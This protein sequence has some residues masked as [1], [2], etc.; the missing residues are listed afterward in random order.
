MSRA[1]RVYGRSYSREDL[2]GIGKQVCKDENVIFKYTEI[3][4]YN[5][6]LTIYALK[7]NEPVNKKISFAE[8]GK[9]SLITRVGEQPYCEYSKMV[10]Y[11]DDLEETAECYAR[12]NCGK[13]LKW[14]VSHKKGALIV[15]LQ[16]GLRV[17][18]FELS[19]YE[20]DRYL[21]QSNNFF[22]KPY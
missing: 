16:F 22:R 2:D 18:K 11:R 1:I 5:N 21:M 17:N 9:Y 7:G 15:H 13:L 19:L 12:M 10:F 14:S 6:A 8:L 3:D 20:V 4:G